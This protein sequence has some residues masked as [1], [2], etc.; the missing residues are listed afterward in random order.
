MFSY[1]FLFIRL[2]V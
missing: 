1:V 2:L